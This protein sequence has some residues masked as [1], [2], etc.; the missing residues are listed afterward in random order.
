MARSR[1][2]VHAL[3]AG[4]VTLP[5][6]YFITPIDDPSSRS[7]VPSL[8]FLI[9]HTDQDTGKIT[10]IV[11]DLG[12]RRRLDDYAKPIRKHTL[13]RQPLS[14]EPD[15]VASLA[16]GGLTPDDIDIVMFSH[17][18]WD[19]I[20]T[21]SDYSRSTYVIGPGAM[22]LINGERTLS[23]GSHSHFEI[24]LLP[25]ER[26]VEL[27]DIESTGREYGHLEGGSS[28]HAE[29]FS[30]PWAAKGPFKATLDV[31]GDGSVYIVSAPGHLDGHINLLCRLEPGKYVYLAGDA[32]HD[33]RLLTGEKDIAT[34]SDPAYPDNV[35]CIHSDREAA[36]KTLA[37]I[38]TAMNNETELGEVEI[39]FAHDA[40]WEKDAKRRKRFFPGTL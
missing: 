29:L 7:T 28:Q 36:T 40:A 12:I 26:T 31:F 17:L 20:G 24:G 34:W 27:P 18:H 22:S 21:P 9:H 5:E 3:S 6:A 1:V 10:R 16:A 19:H 35:C 2:T 13:T 33:R 39:V 11:F 14:G 8:S 15:T 4:H 37:T 38:R 32:C 25:K 23:I 30:K